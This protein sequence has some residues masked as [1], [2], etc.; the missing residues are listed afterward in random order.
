MIDDEGTELR[1]GIEG[2]L[3]V[4]GRPPTLFAGYWELPEESKNAFLGDWCLTG[5]VA[6]MDEDGVFTFVGRAEDVITSSGRTFGPFDV[7]RVLTGH[8]SI[9]AAAVVGIRDLQRGG[10]FVRAFVVPSNGGSEQM[11]AGLRQ[12]GGGGGPPRPAARGT[13]RTCV[14]RP[15][16][17]RLRADGGRAPPVR[18]RD[19]PR[20]AGPP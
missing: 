5:D 12:D 6:Q 16:Q 15:E 11:E 7:E 8:A 1:A 14:R 9:A 3:A 4:R 17:R 18:R 10:H 2:D 20:S 19:A 13:L